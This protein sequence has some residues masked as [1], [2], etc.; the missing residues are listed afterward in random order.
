MTLSIWAGVLFVTGVLVLAFEIGGVNRP[1]VRASTAVLCI[2]VYLRYIYWRLEYSLP[3]QQNGPQTFWAYAFLFI[4]M[5]A[6]LR[7]LFTC[8]F[9]S[10]T[11]N[12][13]AAA[14]A[15]QHSP[16]LHA[17]TDVFIATYNESFEIL[18]RTAVAALAIQHPDLRVWLLDDGDRAWVRDLAD[19]L[20]IN[21]VARHKGKHAK[22]GN[23]NNGVRAALLPVAGPSSSFSLTPTLLL[24]KL[25]C[26]E[27]R[28]F[29]RMNPSGLF[30]HRSTSSIRTPSSPISCVLQLGLMNSAC[31]LTTSYLPRT[32]G[33]LVSAVEHLLSSEW[34]RL[35]KRAEW[36]QRQ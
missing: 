19:S 9:L 23:I 4:E 1:V 33:V 25:F 10:R 28:G 35:K 26:T 21:Y 17:P 12:R 18:E 7:S 30:K 14:D 6:L 34:R 3:Q 36:R 29:L 5:G 32:P 16:L 15:Q 20:G 11:V 2:A 13:S 24:A 8:F 31:S 27:L 22:A